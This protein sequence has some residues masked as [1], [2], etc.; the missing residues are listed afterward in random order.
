MVVCDVGV[1]R[2][3]TMVTPDGVWGP[4]FFYNRWWWDTPF[5]WQKSDNES[6]TSSDGGSE[7]DSDV[8]F[9]IYFLAV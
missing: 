3:T 2:Y 6:E 7:A 8:Y 9:C 4:I 1:V 5:H